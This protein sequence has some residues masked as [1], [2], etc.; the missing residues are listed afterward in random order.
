MSHAYFYAVYF[1]T[2]YGKLDFCK[3]A[4]FCLADHIYFN[5][6]KRQ[7]RLLDS[8]LLQ[9]GAYFTFFPTYFSFQQFFYFLPIFF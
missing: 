6:L 2:F 1:S 3:T 8:H 5:Y 9:G 7:F 4:G